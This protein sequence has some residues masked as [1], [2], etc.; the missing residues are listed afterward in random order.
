MIAPNG[1]DTVIGNTPRIRD[2]PVVAV[3]KMGMSDYDD[4]VV[5]MPIEEAKDFFSTNNGATSLEIMVK[6]PDAVGG[7]VAALAPCGGA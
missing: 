3:F 7:Q 4:S 5:Y 6:D 1:P 2:Y